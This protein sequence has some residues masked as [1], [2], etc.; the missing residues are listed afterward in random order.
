MNERHCG[1]CHQRI[2][3]GVH[4]YTMRVELFPR[5]ADTL[6]IRPEDLELDFDAEMK[7]IIA[8][9]ESMS[10]DEIGQQEERIYTR[11]CFILCPS[12]RDSLVSQFGDSHHVPEP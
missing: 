11:F 1:Y 7:A 5:V 4:P 12:C 10:P 8:Q 9:L 2:P 3:S 6:E